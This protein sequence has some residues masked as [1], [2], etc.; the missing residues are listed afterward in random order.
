MDYNKREYNQRKD[1]PQPPQHDLVHSAKFRAGKRRTY[2]FD[3]R[4][5]PGNDHY[6]TITESTKKFDGTYQRHKMFLYKEDFNRFMREMESVINHVKTDLM[7]EYDYDEFE[8]RQLEWEARVASGEFERSLDD[9]SDDSND[10]E[11]PNSKRP[12]N[13]DDDMSW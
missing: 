7:P 13:E 5:T 4:R 12:N 3:V 9:E 10:K 6:L 2:F 11:I 1:R 8:R